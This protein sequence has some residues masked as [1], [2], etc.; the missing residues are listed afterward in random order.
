MNRGGKHGDL[1]N[2]ACLRS[3][4][5]C[6]LQDSVLEVRAIRRNARFME[7]VFRNAAC[8]LFLALALLPVP[9]RAQTNPPPDRSSRYLFIV[10]TSAAMRRR[11]P[12]VQRV[13]ENL[14]RSSMAAQ[15][16]PGDTVGVWTFDQELSAGKLP[17]Q[18]WSPDRAALVA[19]NVLGF[20]STLRY[21]KKASNFE[22]VM[23]VL[24]RV[25]QDSS[26]LT[27]ILLSDGNEK[28]TGTQFDQQIEAAFAGNFKVQE[29]ARMPFVTV[30]RAARG[31]IRNATVN[32]APWPVEF[33][34]WPPE[35]KLVEAPKP[36]PVEPPAEARPAPRPKLPP[37]IVIGKKPE[38]APTNAAPVISEPPAPVVSAG[39]N[40]APGAPTTA[41]VTTPAPPSTSPGDARSAPPQTVNPLAGGGSTLPSAVTNHPLATPVAPASPPPGPV[42]EPKASKPTPTATNAAPTV[43]AIT[44]P[45]APVTLAVQPEPV[46]NRMGFVAIGFA[47]VLVATGLFLLLHYRARR[48]A[49]RVSLI[50]RSMDRDDQ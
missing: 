50:T 29:K 2:V 24:H 33:P 19:T 37:L 38:P 16:H 49:G 1:E 42:A 39:T 43:G 47:L 32:Q 44:N 45:P 4:R 26:R 3:A 20:L 7:K 35:P 21:E 10:D 13:V 15:F 46:F 6:A 34:E 17:L 8:A 28:I 48:Q 22:V 18:L 41:P 11:A 30:F 27:V 40:L 12:A 14:F 5:L 23:P 36:K 31:Q 9:L 25:V